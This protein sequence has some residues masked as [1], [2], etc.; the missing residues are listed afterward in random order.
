MSFIARDLELNEKLKG[1]VV[2]AASSNLTMF[3]LK[4]EDGTGLFIEVAGTP[5][6]PRL[7]SRLLAADDLPAIGD[8]V[9]K[10]E[11]AWMTSSK[12][13][14]VQSVIGS[15]EINLAPAGK[16]SILSEVS[17]GSLFLSFI[18]AQK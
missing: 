16:L 12:V 11:W 4:F 14:S 10:V 15:F 3:T 13:K 6:S 5:D 2:S 7:E 9:S 1:K 8:S 17:K 18:P